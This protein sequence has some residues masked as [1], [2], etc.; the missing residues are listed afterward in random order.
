MPWAQVSVLTLLVPISQGQI[1]IQ[2]DSEVL[3]GREPEAKH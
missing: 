3:K 2:P 1:H